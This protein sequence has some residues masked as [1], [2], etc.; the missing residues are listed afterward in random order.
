MKFTQ[1][2][3]Y[4]LDLDKTPALRHALK[5]SEQHAFNEVKIEHPADT[6]A[7][8][9]GYSSWDEVL[10]LPLGRRVTG[11]IPYAGKSILG[12]QMLSTTIQ[13]HNF[14]SQPDD[15]TNLTIWREKE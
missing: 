13:D 15:S 14:K 7:K 11:I 9:A 2:L 10:G 4:S 1:N 6:F 3:D 5:L 12:L 8:S